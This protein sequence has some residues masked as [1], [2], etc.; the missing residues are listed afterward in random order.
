MWKAALVLLLALGQPLWAQDDAPAAAITPRDCS[1]EC[2]RQG[3]PGCEY[4]RITRTDLKRALGFNSIKVFGSCI[5]WPCFKFLGEE[6]PKICQ[7]YVQAPNDV[8]VEFVNELNPKSDT[9]VVSWKPSYYGIAF[10]RGFQVSLQALGGSSV[11]C[12]LFLFHRNLSLEA[13]H[14]Q[15]VY[16]SDP[17]PSLSLGSQYAV[18]VMALPVPEQWER[19]YKSKIF[20]TRS[21]AEKNGLEQCEKDW[22]PKHVKVQQEGTAIT[23]TFNLAPPKLGIRSYFSLCYA[24]GMKKYTDITPNSSNNQT[25]HSYQLKDLQ[26][27]TNYTCEIAANQVDAVRKTFYVQVLHLQKEHSPPLSVTPSLALMLPL[28]LSAG[29]ILVVSLVA[30]TLRRPRLQIKKFDIKPDFL[31]I[32]SDIIKEHLESGT[33]EEVM[34]LSKNRPT[35]PRLLICYSSRDGPAHVNAV[36]QLGAFIQQHMATQVCLDLWQSL[37]VAEEGSMAWHCR[38]IRES[39]FILVICSQGLNHRLKPPEGDDQDDRADR[40]LDFGSNAFSSD[41][42]VQLIGEEVGRAKARGQDLSKYM[43]AIFEYSEETDIP[44]ELRLVSHYMLTSDLQLLF[45]HLHGVALHRPGH[46]L[47]INHISEEGFTKLPAGAALQLAIYEAQLAMMAKWHQ[48]VE[49]GD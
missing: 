27:G 30:L 25:H 40:G 9:I 24:N 43:A 21:C 12:Q 35:P 18:T 38:Q 19:F 7:H 1:L 16:K 10:L 14:A 34:P 13:S 6:D 17:F 22:Y 42:A 44:T 41:T 2:I 39:D 37:R 33:Q 49:G 3:G 20:S 8:K 48:S 29:V 36:M 4:C 15:R 47:K 28:G 26:E 5:P 45:S 32:H 11:D 23:V 31:A 46:Y